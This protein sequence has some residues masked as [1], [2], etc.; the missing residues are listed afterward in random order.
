VEAAKALTGADPCDRSSG[1]FGQDR[2]ATAL[3]RDLSIDTVPA[4]LTQNLSPTMNLQV[5]GFGQV[6]T[7]N[8]MGIDQQFIYGNSL[9][10]GVLLQIG[11]LGNYQTPQRARPRYPGYPR[12]SAGSRSFSY[13]L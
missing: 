9:I 4:T 7:D 5:A 12:H 1:V 13:T 3:G 2:P 10:D 8:P 6:L 11:L